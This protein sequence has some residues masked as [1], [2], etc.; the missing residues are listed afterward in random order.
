MVFVVLCEFK[1]FSE[2]H[3]DLIQIGNMRRAIIIKSLCI[4]HRARPGSSFTAINPGNDP[5]KV[6]V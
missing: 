6:F 5:K 1:V 4:D 2:R 3:A